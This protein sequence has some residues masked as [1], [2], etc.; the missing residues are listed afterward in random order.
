MEPSI[1]IF[2][3]VG[4]DKQELISLHQKFFNTS[5]EYTFN[6]VQEFLSNSINISRTIP[7][8]RNIFRVTLPASYSIN[9]DTDKWKYTWKWLNT[10]VKPWL[11]FPPNLIF[12][13][14]RGNSIYVFLQMFFTFFNNVGIKSGKKSSFFA[15]KTT[16]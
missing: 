16:S 9:S 2:L 11:I 5:H 8:W 13:P 14:N 15:V 7:R 10:H 12:F 1:E 6:S 3:F 4:L